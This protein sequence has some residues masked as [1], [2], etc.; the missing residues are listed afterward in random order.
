MTQKILLLKIIRRLVVRKDHGLEEEG[1]PNLA[2]LAA[3]AAL[4]TKVD[5][6]NDRGDLW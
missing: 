3:A 1:L 6:I 5:S 4:G 2:E